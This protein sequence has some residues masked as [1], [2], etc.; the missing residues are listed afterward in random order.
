MG[1]SC[2]SCSFL[3]ISGLYL[4]PWC[5]LFFLK[6]NCPAAFL[7]QDWNG[8]ASWVFHLPKA[9]P[10]HEKRVIEARGKWAKEGTI[11]GRVHPINQNVAQT[12]LWIG[13]GSATAAAGPGSRRNHYI[14]LLRDKWRHK[15]LERTEASNT[16]R[17]K[18]DRGKTFFFKFLH[19]SSPP[20][21]VNLTKFLS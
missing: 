4:Q 15:S 21:F 9:S 10:A 7:L 3:K 16:S 1:L 2:H 13:V 20:T 14:A 5:E 18:D 11:I 8:I 12:G 17:T 19:F 6:K